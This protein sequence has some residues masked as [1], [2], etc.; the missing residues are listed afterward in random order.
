MRRSSRMLA[1]AV[2]LAN[3]VAV[4]EGAQSADDGEE[5]PCLE[6]HQAVSQAFA[7]TRMARAATGSDFVAEWR[8]TG[9]PPYC[10]GCHAP[11]GGEGL[12]CSD[13]HGAG[14]H[15]Y[16]KVEVPGACG[17]C[18]DA[19]GEST[20][21]RF[22][23]GPAHR[24][25]LGCL[26]CHTGDD[27]DGADHA[28]QGPSVEGYLDRIAEVRVFLRRNATASRAAIVRIAH[29]AGHGLPG[30]TTGRSVWLLV[31]GIKLGGESAWQETVRFGWEHQPDGSWLDRTL[32]PGR[33]A[34]LEFAR[35][36][37][38]NAVRLRVELW[39]RFLP[40]PLDEP[41]PRAVLLSSAEVDLLHG[42]I[43]P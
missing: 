16:P 20:V 19:P 27:S 8:E 40:G 24:H 5:R 43:E 37:R 18:H 34:I 36:E 11:S 12:V 13:C 3:A 38:S 30:G 25:G 23:E 17:R 29:K 28:F 42:Q 33:P 35:P 1:C 22:L 26:D 21:R 6:C 31:R 41:D 10:L 32:A 7:G 2:S 4:A 14:P 15:P 39:Y 9:Y